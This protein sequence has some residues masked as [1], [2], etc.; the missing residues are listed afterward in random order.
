MT[1]DRSQNWLVRSAA[2]IGDL[3]NPF[4]GEERQRDVWNEASA[5][6]LQVILWLSFVAATVA[7]WFVGEPAVPYVY[8]LIGIIGVAS[9]VAVLYSWSLGV[10]I[11]NPAWLNRRR[12]AAVLVLAALLAAGLLRATASGI[13]VDDWSTVAGMVTGAGAV[14]VVLALVS[15]SARKRLA[16][17]DQD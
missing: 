4:Y 17:R 10:Q 7:V 5:V 12:L 6:A 15:R 13:A 11:D 3:S 8:T 14:L 1:A 9:W 16:A 2:V